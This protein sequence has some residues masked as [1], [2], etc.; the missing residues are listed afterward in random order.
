ME[1]GI[2]RAKNICFDV[3]TIDEPIS[4]LPDIPQIH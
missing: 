2:F 4:L 3:V 1:E